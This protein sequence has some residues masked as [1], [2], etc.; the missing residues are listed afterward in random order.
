MAWSYGNKRW[1]VPFVSLNGTSCRVDIYKRGYTDSTVETLTGAANPFEYEEDD[2]EDLLNGVI[3]YR[4]GYLRLIESN[5]GDL[6]DVYPSVNTDRYI[7]FYYGSTLDFNG[8]IQAQEF[9]NPWESGPR[10]LELPV[11][12]PLGLAGG[13]KFSY[14]SYNPPS[15]ITID[16]LI[17]ASLNLLGGE[18]T[19]YYFPQSLPNNTSQMATVTKGLYV[20]SLTICPWGDTYN[21]SG[22]YG[23]LTGIYEPRNV[24]DA[25]MAVCTTFGVILHDVPGIPIFQRVDWQGDYFLSSFSGSASLRQQGI[26]DLTSIAEVASNDND[27]SVVLPLSKI[28]VTID[29]E[30]NVPDMTFK[31]CHGYARGCAIADREFCTNKPNIQDLQGTFNENVSI[32]DN[33]LFGVDGVALGAY[34]GDSLTEMIMFQKPNANLTPFIASYTFFEWWGESM[35]LRF[36]FKYGTSIENLENPSGLHG[37]DKIAVRLVHG[38][39]YYNSNNRTWQSIGSTVVYSKEWSGINEDC[40]LQFLP[41]NGVTPGV[42]KVEFYL[43]LYGDTNSFIHTISNVQLLNF[44]SASDAYLGKNANP[45]TRTIIGDPSNIEGSVTKW[46]DITVYNTHRIRQGSS[47]TGSIW[48]DIVNGRPN[49]PYLLKAQD[50]LQIDMK[51]TY[52]SPLTIYLNRFTLWGSS[53]NWRTIARTFRPWDDIRRI[54]FHHS[55]EFD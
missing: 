10:I 8:Y 24:Y 1:T 17:K 35:R 33:G 9:D 4:T 55:T 18:Y 54:T 25:L 47:I 27:E 37:Y 26:T 46:Y 6:D 14:V 42:L 2:D 11:I 12:S 36:K 40:E 28:N 45:T 50:R 15:W 43:S 23:D 53:V 38:N 22:V 49:Y 32:N 31:R 19:G 21:K 39:Y 7:E 5:R 52:Q 3:R 13:T 51:M 29:G 48:A 44:G 34:G 20:N 16:Q 30:D 41:H